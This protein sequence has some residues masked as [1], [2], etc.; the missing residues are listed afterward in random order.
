M[1]A[2]VRC[3]SNSTLVAILVNLEPSALR[4]IKAPG[5]KNVAGKRRF[6]EDEKRSQLKRSTRFRIE[7]G[8]IMQMKTALLVALCASF[9]AAIG[10]SFA[11]QPSQKAGKAGAART[12]ESALRRVREGLQGRPSVNFL[13]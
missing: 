7:K 13:V 12:R 8:E 11:Q 10:S 1:P 4:Q 5:F 9:A 2:T 6:T 3:T